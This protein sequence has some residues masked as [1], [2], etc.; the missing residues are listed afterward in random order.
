MRNIFS[1]LFVA[2]ILFN[3][4]GYY[5]LFLGLLYTNNLRADRQ[6]DAEDFAGN[7]VV[8]LKIP[9][10]VPYAIYSGD[11]EYKHARGDFEHKGE[12]YRLVKQRLFQDTLYVVCV[13]DE[14]RASINNAFEKY[15]QTF[16][17]HTPDFAKE[18]RTLP[19]FIKDFISRDFAILTESAGWEQ[20]LSRHSH[21]VLF[22]VDYH[23]SVNHPPEYT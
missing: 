18:L 16:S 20:C 19:G 21:S 5:G 22:P 7:P 14:K 10:T 12:F 15:V 8:T 17:D 11:G 1:Y 4:M 6:L 9:I 3:V 13:K 23:P 2:L